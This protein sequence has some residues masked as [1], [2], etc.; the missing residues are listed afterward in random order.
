MKIR[1]FYVGIK[2]RITDTFI[3]FY[4]IRLIS[5][6]NWYY[7]V[8]IEN[9]IYDINLEQILTFFANLRSRNP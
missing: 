6:N 1:S 3:D 9:G 5:L 8:L 4:R 7:V 2:Q